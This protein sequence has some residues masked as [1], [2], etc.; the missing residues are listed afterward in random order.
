MAKNSGE[1]TLWLKIKTAGEEALDNISNAFDKVK[2]AAVAAFALVS[3]AIVKGIA[4]Y[5]EAE[6]ASRALTQAMVNSGIY[7]EKLKTIYD[8]QAEALSKV[9]TFSD[10]QITK[11]QAVIQQ[12]I[13]QIQVTDKLTKAILDFATA[14]GIDAASAAETVGKS[15]GTATNALGRY[16]IEVNSSASETEKMSQVIDGINRKFGDQSIAAAQG[17]G[18]LSQLKNRIADVFE[19]LG[20]RLSPAIEYFSKQLMGFLDTGSAVSTTIDIIAGGIK[21]LTMGVVTVAATFDRLGATIG[22]TA[23]AI[24]SFFTTA[25]KSQDAID[26]IFNMRKQKQLE[27]EKKIEEIE[28]AFS[29]AKQAREEEELKR[30]ETNLNNR[31]ELI[32]VKNEEKAIAEMEN[33]IALQEQATMMQDFGTEEYFRKEAE[34]QG[35][36]AEQAT[37]HKAKMAALNNQH[38][39]LQLANQQ[40]ATAKEIELEKKKNE[41]IEAD[42]KSTLGTIAGL[43]NE[44]NQTLATIGKAAALTQIA[45]DTPVAISRALAAFPPPFNY[46]AA[47]A[48]GAAMAAQAAKVSGIKLAE[49]GIVKAR[50]GGIQATI[51]EGGQD[52]AVIPLDKM[53]QMG[54]NTYQINVYGGLLGDEATAY[55]LAIALDQEL[56]KLR[57]NNESVAFDKGVL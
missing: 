14:Q 53:G 11:A 40:K 41:I 27:Y 54:G 38:N 16:G 18:V 48:V 5:K 32:R 49:G 26:E 10:D 52:E 7:S 30:I 19:A 29:G 31:N 6:D 9:T 8:Q 2:V 43:Q 15:I 51:G 55:R 12:Q 56:Y 3:A 47:A 23:V 25:I 22:Q 17:L 20:Q 13:G 42:R 44:S 34:A 33:Q 39:L 35:K 28:A 57:K 21:Y 4:E 46:G 1:A 36:L 24:A 37:N 50:P 45:I